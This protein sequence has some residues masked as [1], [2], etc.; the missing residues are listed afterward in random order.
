MLSEFC[1]KRDAYHHT[2]LFLNHDQYIIMS[3]H[4]CVFVCLSLSFLERDI[5]IRM[6]MN[7]VLGSGKLHH[8]VV[9]LTKYPLDSNLL[10]HRC[11]SFVCQGYGYVFLHCPLMAYFQIL[12]YWRRLCSVIVCPHIPSNAWLVI[13]HLVGCCRFSSVKNQK[14]SSN[15]MP[16]K[17]LSPSFTLVSFIP[18]VLS[19]PIVFVAF[20]ATVSTRPRV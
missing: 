5:Q 8:L 14:S 9:R 17:M 4:A 15:G 2:H 3:T 10:Q 13:L 20:Q 11:V 12:S 16:Q 19:A 18:V 7:A 6:G 1:C